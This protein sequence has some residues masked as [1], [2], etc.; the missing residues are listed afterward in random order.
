VR[1]QIDGDDS[2]L[3]LGDTASQCGHSRSSCGWTLSKE[4]LIGLHHN[5]HNQPCQE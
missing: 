3:S 4:R 2:R 1:E 5:L